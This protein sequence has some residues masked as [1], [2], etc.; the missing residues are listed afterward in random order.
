MDISSKGFHY[1]LFSVLSPRLHL[2]NGFREMT[3]SNPDFIHDVLQFLKTNDYGD[4]TNL[5][6]I[7]ILHQAITKAAKMKCSN[8][9]N[10]VMH[11]VEKDSCALENNQDIKGICNKELKN[12][13]A[14][15]VTLRQTFYSNSNQFK[16]EVQIVSQA[17]CPIQLHLRF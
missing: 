13:Q 1:F 5:S 16:E 6:A 15:I 9:L 12:R 2:Q 3:S 14:L 4:L 10:D 17:E 11:K 7:D 8:E